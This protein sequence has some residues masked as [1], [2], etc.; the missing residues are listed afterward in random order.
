MR[1]PACRIAVSWPIDLIDVGEEKTARVRATMQSIL[2]HNPVKL[3]AAYRRK[4]YPIIIS[5][6]VRTYYYAVSPTAYL[7]T[8]FPFKPAKWLSN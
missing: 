4:M 2:P 8:P 5:A 6:F 7:T 3:H 1:A